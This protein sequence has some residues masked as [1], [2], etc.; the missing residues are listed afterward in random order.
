[1]KGVFDTRPLTEYDD[2]I[3][4]RYHFPNRYLAEA[5]RTKKDWIVYRE[6]RRGGGR[7][8]YVAVA[9]VIPTAPRFD[10]RGFPRA[11]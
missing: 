7:Q 5:E 10:S 11:A 6:P 4:L 3:N 9:R 2:D 8:A 1:M